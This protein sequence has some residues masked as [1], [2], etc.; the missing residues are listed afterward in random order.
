MFRPDTRSARSAVGRVVQ[1]RLAKLSSGTVTLQVIEKAV[2]FVEN[3]NAN[4]PPMLY[5]LCSFPPKLVRDSRRAERVRRGKGETLLN[6]ARLAL[7]LASEPALYLWRVITGASRT[8][9]PRPHK[10]ELFQLHARFLY[11]FV[12]ASNVCALSALFCDT[13]SATAWW[14]RVWIATAT[15]RQAP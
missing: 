6:S 4:L 1:F 3:V 13:L 11:V 8:L 14:K 15:A 5:A 2:V 9:V 7:F 10:L 12:A